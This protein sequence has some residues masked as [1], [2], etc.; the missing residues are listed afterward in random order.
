MTAPDDDQPSLGT[1]LAR[2]LSLVRQLVSM[3]PGIYALGVL[4]AVAFVSAIIASAVVIGNVS[5]DLI[6]PVLDGGASTQ[7]R[8]WPAMAAVAGVALWKA[9]GITFRRV[10]AG[11]L[12]A[13]CQAD[14]RERLIDR[15]LRL[16]LRWHQHRGVGDLLAVADS[17]AGN[18]TWI[19]APLPYATGTILLLVG[20]AALIFLIDPLLALVA[21][22]SLAAII[23]IDV[24]GSWKM[25]NLFQVIQ[26][27]QGE[28]ARVVHESFD[29]ALTVKALGREQY[30]TDRLRVASE[31][32]RDHISRIGTVWAGY[33][34]FVEGM[35]SAVTV[36]LLVVGATRL[37]NGAIT[38]GDLVTIAY[39]FSLLSIPIRVVG[40]MLWDMAHS[41]AS[42]TR[43]RA[44]H[45]S[46]D[47]VEY[48]N[49]NSREAG[50][51]A[52]IDTSPIGFSYGDQVILQD[53]EVPIPPGTTVAIVGPTG[54]GKSTLATLL[55]RLWDPT[56]GVI[57]L[58]DRDLRDF[59]RSALPGEV[60]FVP[61]ETFLFD[62][63]VRANIAI[64]D[65][66]DDAA[67]ALAAELGGAVEFIETL[68]Y[69]YDT[70]LGERGT[71]L[72]GGQR[73]RVALAR[74]LV[75][76]PRLL[77]LDDATSSVDASVEAEI[78]E[79]LK[80]AELPS[81]IVIVAYRRSSILLAD[82]II[83][84]EDGRILGRGSHSK[85]LAITGYAE[86]LEAYDE[87]NG[88]TPETV[89]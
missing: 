66:P 37:Q 80:R 84:L 30:E 81:T 48:G 11:W 52:G 85:L 32:L 51:G 27:G 15:M 36:L 72:S 54:S 79:S 83:Y 73:Q 75:R 39:L 18:S 53:L 8:L 60:A 12:Q 77:I 1:V 88:N 69:R 17:D 40:F 20:T 45:E 62:D 63:T 6:I 35:L 86:I 10:G 67:V 22:V 47:L 46:D 56:S 24:R 43:V 65:Q 59:A 64:G 13:R 23:S 19:L 78:L 14:V 25:F 9:L 38:G 71:T 28:V 74:A 41:T 34:V 57:R 58:D 61:Q 42:W 44:V 7:G 55:A 89:S 87:Q 26:R 68:P 49:L 21:V 16:E 3:H 5:D 76:T 29:G 82:E 4:G 2:G 50:T 31:S 33:R 70:M